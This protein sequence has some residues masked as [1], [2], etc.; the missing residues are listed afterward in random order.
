MEK[1]NIINAQKALKPLTYQQN[2]NE[3]QPFIQSTIEASIG[4]V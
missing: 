3:N 1:G 2:F 4:E